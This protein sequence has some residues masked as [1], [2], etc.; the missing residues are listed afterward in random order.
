VNCCSQSAEEGQLIARVEAAQLTAV[1]LVEAVLAIAFIVAEKVA[2]HALRAALA[3]SQ[4]VVR[5]TNW[6]HMG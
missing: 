3:T 6:Q 4:L 5:T 2:R 1:G